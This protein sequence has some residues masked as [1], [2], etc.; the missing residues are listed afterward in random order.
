MLRGTSD[1][2]LDEVI[3]HIL[4]SKGGQGLIRS[5]RPVK[6]AIFCKSAPT[7]MVG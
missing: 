6:S 1:I 5:H 7:L 4:D 2:V 3:V